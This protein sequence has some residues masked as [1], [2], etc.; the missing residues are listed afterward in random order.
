[1]GRPPPTVSATSRGT[2]KRAAATGATTSRT[3]RPRRPGRGAD[4]SRSDS[5]ASGSGTDVLIGR[6]LEP[7]VE[8]GA[9]RAGRDEHNAVGQQRE[10]DTA[11][12]QGASAP[13]AL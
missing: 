5:G 13:R 12:G 4:A 8:E 1:M 10:G 2:T 9:E 7:E 6:R 11:R 3:R